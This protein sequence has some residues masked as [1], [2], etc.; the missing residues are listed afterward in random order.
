M[1]FNLG[2][3]G[4]SILSFFPIGSKILGGSA[5]PP[6]PPLTTPLLGYRGSIYEKH[7][8]PGPYLTLNV[9][10][11]DDNLNNTIPDLFRHVIPSQPNQIKDYVHVPLV[12]CGIL[13]SQYGHF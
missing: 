12:I 11:V 10:A 2:G 4:C 13:F 9:L 7:V 6:D 5:D 3:S 1:A 8:N